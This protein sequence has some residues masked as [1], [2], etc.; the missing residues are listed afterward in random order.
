MMTVLIIFFFSLLMN[1]GLFCSA[2]YYQKKL[3]KITPIILAMYLIA[4]VIT[5]TWLFYAFIL[6]RAWKKS[7]PRQKNLTNEKGCEDL[8]SNL[9]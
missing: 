3:K 7:L 1:I 6:Q 2:I 8:G 5:V 4:S 9:N